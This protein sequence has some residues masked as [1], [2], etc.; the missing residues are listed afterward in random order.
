MNDTATPSPNVFEEAKLMAKAKH[1]NPTQPLDS[2]FLVSFSPLSISGH[3]LA[4]MHIANNAGQGFGIPFEGTIDE[5]IDLYRD[6]VGNM[7]LQSK[8]GKF[9]G[10]EQSGNGFGCVFQNFSSVPGTMDGQYVRRLVGDEL[11]SK[12][13]DSTTKYTLM[14]NT[15]ELK[16]FLKV[17]GI[18]PLTPMHRKLIELA[19]RYDQKGFVGMVMN[20]LGGEIQR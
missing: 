7:L 20:S 10:Y 6:Q 15:P 1:Y 19:D 13:G 8:D 16:K 2:S 14:E 9:V 3:E 17:N 4:A 18:E 12:K 5:R 11:H